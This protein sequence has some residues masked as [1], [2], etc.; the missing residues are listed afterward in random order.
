MLRNLIDAAPSKRA[1]LF[2][3]LSFSRYSRALAW[4]TKRAGLG[5]LHLVPHSA[6]HGGA[7][8]D[9]AGQLR[10]LAEVQQRGLW[11]HPRSVARYRK[12]GLYHKQQARMTDEHRA[13]ARRAALAL[14][15][16]LS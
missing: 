12:P 6:R 13:F 5:A 14:P 3:E 16:L 15:K 1:R 7:S 11:K 8:A 10:S 2:G 9:A 4:A